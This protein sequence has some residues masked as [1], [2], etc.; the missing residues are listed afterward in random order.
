[1]RRSPQIEGMPPTALERQIAT[2]VARFDWARIAREVDAEGWS[3]LGALLSAAECHSLVQ[4][5]DEARFRS[6]VDMAQHRFGRG[7]YRYFAT[8]LPPLVAALRR[9]AYAQLAPIANRWMEALGGNAYP[10]TLAAYLARCHAAGQERPTPL[11]LRYR[12]GDYN[13]LHQDL[14]G[15]HAFPLQVVIPLSEPGRDHEGGELIFTEQRPRSQS[16]ATAVAPAAGE[17]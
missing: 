10:P 8:P 3:R 6:T 16:R 5:Y 15:E 9:A 7:Q 17:A 12:A 14:Y 4:A 2:R 11:L 13:C 1:M